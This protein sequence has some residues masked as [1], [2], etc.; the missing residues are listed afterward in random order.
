MDDEQM[1]IF[2]CLFPTFKITKPIRLIELFAGIGA[3]SKALER[4][5]ADFESWRIC[6]W[7][8]PSILA[9]SA[10]HHC[11]TGKDYTE[12]MTKDQVADRLAQIGVSSDYNTP[13]TAEQTRRLPESKARAIYNAIEDEHNLVDISRAHGKDFA[14]EKQ[15][16]RKHAYIMTYSFPCQDLSLAGK[17]AGMKKE[18]GTRS[19]LLWEVERILHEL[20]RAVELPDVLL[21]ENVPQVIDAN[22]INDFNLWFNSLSSMGYR[23]YVSI[24]NSK[25]Y[26]IPQNRKRCFMV[27]CL[28]DYY[29]EFPMKQKN[30]KTLKE[31]L[32][33]DVSQK[34]FLSEKMK[35][36]IIRGFGIRPTTRLFNKKPA[37]TLTTRK[38]NGR[39]GQ[40]N[41]IC[42]KLPDNCSLN[43]LDSLAIQEAT[44][45]GYAIAK[46]GDGVDISARGNGH[47]GKVQKEM[48]Q[49]I[50]T[51][52]D[53]GVVV[54]RVDR[55][56]QTLDI[57]SLTPLECYRLMGFDD[58]DFNNA[59]TVLSDSMLYHT[60][61][62]SIVVNVLEAIFRQML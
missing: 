21:M 11:S 2:S 61:G 47:R 34:Y 4:I 36:Y 45:K 33:H 60:A 22:N 1:D 20:A 54:S 42:D 23:S 14:I 53:C 29:Y 17:R 37:G 19:G 9:Y 50:K 38:R 49:T 12:G 3:Q 44:K 41:Y 13:M 24:L 16:D 48:S 62:D 8:T 7:A 5:G 43:Q 51:S 28:G 31:L 55:F 27:S 6:E 56:M 52:I 35:K 15:E 40:S 10:I 32:E 18:S 59:R 30:R 26:G 25:D 58:E 57:R 46:E 39:A